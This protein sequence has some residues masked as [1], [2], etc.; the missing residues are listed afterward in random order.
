MISFELLY[1]TYPRSLQNALPLDCRSKKCRY[2]ARSIIGEGASGIVFLGE[3]VTKNE[4]V[5]IKVLHPI[6]PIIPTAEKL[7]TVV[8][9]FL[10]EIRYLSKLEH[11]NILTVKDAGS[12]TTPGR[13]QGFPFYVT[14]YIP[15]VKS[16]QELTL[17]LDSQI[18]QIVRSIV[19]G[20][21]YL[22][23]KGVLHRDIKSQNILIT[24]NV[25]K[26][27]DFGVAKWLLDD[28][29]I[30]LTESS[31]ILTTWDY[32]PPEAELSAKAYTTA[33]DVWSLG[34]T[35]L[36]LIQG[37]KTKRM[38][39]L[40]SKGLLLMS[41]RL[42]YGFEGV[43]VHL[44]QLVDGMLNIDPK[45][46]PSLI[47][48]SNIIDK[49]QYCHSRMFTLSSKRI[50]ALGVEIAKYIAT[51]E[52]SRWNTGYS[53]FSVHQLAYLAEKDLAIGYTCPSCRKSIVYRIGLE[54]ETWSED[55]RGPK[56]DYIQIC[57]GR[58]NKSCG[59]ILDSFAD[60]DQSW[61]QIHKRY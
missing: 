20:L 49:V 54:Y 28:N 12:V 10:R 4:T 15:R 51:Q 60:M 29:V 14:Q 13:L 38:A 56:L 31:E 9:R 45:C 41:H 6:L 22:H 35:F 52:K 48:I 59:R 36:E 61:K 32:L 21:L 53:H 44:E 5:A 57:T 25:V 43:L 3:N 19:D 1:P 26:L 23:N 46:R 34:K 18:L 47:D 27:C 58:Q 40:L 42:Q 39:L 2:I 50:S 24:D 7:N 33:S 37:R 55:M 8:D 16:D 11:R 30:N 17:I